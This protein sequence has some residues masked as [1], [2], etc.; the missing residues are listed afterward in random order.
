MF[1]VL[2]ENLVPIRCDHSP[3]R[4]TAECPASAYRIKRVVVRVCRGACPM[5]DLGVCPPG[6]LLCET[7]ADGLMRTPRT[8]L[9]GDVTVAPA[10][11]DTPSRVGVEVTALVSIPDSNREEV[12]R[13]RFVVP[14]VRES[15]RV[16]EVWLSSLCIGVECPPETSCGRRS[17]EPV[18]NPP[19]QS[20]T[21]LPEAGVYDGGDLDASFDDATRRD[22]FPPRDVSDAS[23]ASDA[24]VMD[25]SDV[26][27]VSVTD[28]SDVSDA[29]AMD[30]SD[31]S[32]VSVTDASDVIDAPTT[33]LLLTESIEPGD[34]TMATGDRPVADD[35]GA[36]DVSS[37]PDS[38]DVACATCPGA[39][40]CCGGV[41]VDTTTSP[42]HC[43]Q[44]DFG[45]AR[46]SACVGGACERLGEF[47]AGGDETCAFYGRALRCWG[48]NSDGRL[49]PASVALRSTPTRVEGSGDHV[50]MSATHSCAWSGS[51]V[52]GCWGRNARGALG[53]IN[54]SLT[55]VD[56]I[57]SL[58]PDSLAVGE[59]FS[60]ATRGAGDGEVVCWGANDL[61]QSGQ[62]GAADVDGPTAV[63]GAPASAKVVAG[64][65]HVCSLSFPGPSRRVFCW[66]ANGRGQTGRG[67][68]TAREGAA[69][70]TLSEPNDI[71]AGRDHACAITGSSLLCWGANESRQSDPS[72]AID[73]RT[74]TAVTGLPSGE[75]PLR[76]GAAGD[77]FTCVIGATGAV[78][79]WGTG[80]LGE[81]GDA[82]VRV[83][84]EPRLVPGLTGVTAITAGA[85]HVCARN[86]AGLHCWGGNRWA[87]LGVGT[88]GQP[89]STPAAVSGVSGT[90]ASVSV[91][92]GHVC[93]VIGGQVRCWGKNAD[94]QLGTGDDANRAEP[95]A[96]S[97]LA[98]PN[99]VCTGEAFSCAMSASGAVQ[100]WGRNVEGQLGRNTFSASGPTGMG[101]VGVSQ[102]AAIACGA[103]HACVIRR[104]TG[105]VSCWGANNRGQIGQPRSASPASA[106]PLDV[107]GI[108]N[109]AA[110]A[111]GGD[112]TCAALRDGTVRC[113]GNNT[114]G[115]LGSGPGPDGG[116]ETLSE[117]PVA[118]TGVS[119]ASGVS[120][121][122][123]HA[124]A[125]GSTQSW[126]W[127]FNGFAQLGR[128]AA[129]MRGEL[130]GAI[131]G[132]AAAQG[133]GSGYSHACSFDPTGLRCWGRNHAGQV[134]DGLAVS[135]SSIAPTPVTVALGGSGGVRAV[136]AGGGSAASDVTAGVTA[137][138]CAH[139]GAAVLCWGSNEWGELGDGAAFR[140]P[141]AVVTF[142]P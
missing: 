68:A 105:A 24:S 18:N 55:R 54:A 23:D 86:A 80:E 93:A 134:G 97:M 36:S 7:Y 53:V 84:T 82:T 22:V 19:T 48:R 78:Y 85:R 76:G 109:A 67:T 137:M 50:A 110:I 63:A 12:I 32:D 128:G 11:P 9:P 58:L 41:C 35:G 8:I 38:S 112:S 13:R 10:D 127:G 16:V 61:G 47:S 57:A 79:C 114:F 25:A 141:P 91:G 122:V 102:A 1:R 31:V 59:D 103:R 125:W 51:G 14:F 60:C 34:A 88:S 116:I 138:T 96:V 99:A 123:V 46:G 20:F 26:S 3:F 15:T 120:M 100:C 115:E 139:D 133:I 2:G 95:A 74:P 129:T 37:A 42:V 77:T 130:P 73:V 119:G 94:G 28:A 136:S 21:P 121:G 87:Q 69:L 70:V 44:C 45:C 111:A 132:I 56:R 64:R 101:V 142:T 52:V 43:G 107:G 117:T 17:C 131:T 108:V 89:R 49:G 83:A 30:A 71:F 124:C 90:V 39:Q 135:V 29:S 4:D 140:A 27:D 118:V 5:A 66:G 33:D 81:L 6:D 65:A 113:W 72:T 62:T 75:H 92:Y 126:C 104:T 98:T 40:M 106:T